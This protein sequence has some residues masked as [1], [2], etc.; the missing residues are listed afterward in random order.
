MS[1]S[2]AQLLLLLKS[3]FCCLPFYRLQLPS[4]L[5]ER[6]KEREGEEEKDRETERHREIY[7]YP[8]KIAG[9]C[10]QESSFYPARTKTIL[11]LI[12]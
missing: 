4:K 1:Q 6:R 10:Y 3:Y 12:L 5:G 8:K 2:L 7:S 9:G 11:S